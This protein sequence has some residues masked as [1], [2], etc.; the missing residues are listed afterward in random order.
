MDR[1]CGE[2]C[3]EL[4]AEC[5]TWLFEWF[6]NTCGDV[7]I[8]SLP[9]DSNGLAIKPPKQHRSDSEWDLEVEQIETDTAL[10]LEDYSKNSGEKYS[11]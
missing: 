4:R 9:K 1:G 7:E 5:L 2:L 8:H 6:W 3:N 10:T 11:T